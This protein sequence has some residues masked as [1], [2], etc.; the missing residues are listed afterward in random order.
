MAYCTWE[1]IQNFLPPILRTD[2]GW[3]T[4][5]TGLIDSEEAKLNRRLGRR[6]EVPIDP[7]ASPLAYAWCVQIAAM[8]VGAEAQKVKRGTEASG[9]TVGWF[10]NSLRNDAS[11]EIAEAVD[12]KGPLLDAVLVST[13][14]DVQVEDGYAELTA[15][16][17]CKLTPNFSRDD[18]W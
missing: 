15:E 8:C 6:Y 14:S 9:E 16:Q 12:G 11:K 2:T 7:T 13:R 3:E 17:Q 4:V 5:A 10:A 1:E 18:K